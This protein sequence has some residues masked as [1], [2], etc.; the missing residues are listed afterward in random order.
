[1]DKL[2]VG[3]VAYYSPGDEVYTPCAVDWYL[4]RNEE[5]GKHYICHNQNLKTW[6]DSDWIDKNVNPGNGWNIKIAP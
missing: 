2:I 6:V 4:F 1:M 3:K 5:T